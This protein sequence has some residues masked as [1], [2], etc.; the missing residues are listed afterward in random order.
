MPWY[1]WLLIAG[2]LG[3]IIGSLLLLRDS[4]KRMPI[5]ADALER[6]K[7]RNQVLEEQEQQDKE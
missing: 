3:S 4:A 5:D 1:I 7:Q 6:M 2:V